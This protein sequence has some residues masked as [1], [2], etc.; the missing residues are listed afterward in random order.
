MEV[1][2]FQRIKNSF[3]TFF[4]E[5]VDLIL[6]ALLKELT[7]GFTMVP[8]KACLVLST[9]QEITIIVTLKLI[10]LLSINHFHLEIVFYEI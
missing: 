1:S 7:I 2:L 8:F 9:A 3:L 10:I 4:K 6:S 5:N